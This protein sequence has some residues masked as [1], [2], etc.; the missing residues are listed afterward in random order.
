MQ[1]IEI[2]SDYGQVDIQII[3]EYEK[4][5]GYRFPTIYK[6]LLL[7]H[8]GLYPQRDTF[9]YYDEAIKREEENGIYFYCFDNDNLDPLYSDGLIGKDLDDEDF[10]DTSLIP[11]GGTGNGDYICFDYSENK[12]TD[13]PKIVVLHHDAPDD[14]NNLIFSFLGNSFEE[15]MDSLYE[16]VDESDSF[17]SHDFVGTHI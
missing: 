4:I 16:Y 14:D 12:F 9:A 17:R 2:N 11:F 5:I 8:N 7:K 15:F 3:N 13:N 1:K 10:I 6:E